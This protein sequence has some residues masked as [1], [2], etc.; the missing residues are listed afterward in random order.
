[1]EENIYF[2]EIGEALWKLKSRSLA[3]SALPIQTP[4]RN[5]SQVKC[6][7]GLDIHVKNQRK[8]QV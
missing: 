7:S 1:M 4:C 5:P 6:R 8:I 2:I 3:Q